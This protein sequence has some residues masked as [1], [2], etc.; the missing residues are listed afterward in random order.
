MITC[1]DTIQPLGYL[2]W[3]ACG[4]DPGFS[5]L[6]IL[7]QAAQSSRYTQIELEELSFDGPSPDL[8]NL[9]RKWRKM[10]KAAHVLIDHLPS[11]EAGNC[12]LD[13]SGKLYSGDQ[14]QLKRDRDAEQLLFHSGSIRGAYPQIL[15]IQ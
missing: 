8:S 5:P 4:K 1:H 2:A 15:D 12:V 7:E 13:C 6:T 3:A 14:N 10:L 11:E 9:S